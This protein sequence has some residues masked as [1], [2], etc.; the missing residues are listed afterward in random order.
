MEIDDFTNA[1]AGLDKAEGRVE[2]TGNLILF[3]RKE[4][5]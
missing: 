4:L 5:V 2:L 3:L 1:C